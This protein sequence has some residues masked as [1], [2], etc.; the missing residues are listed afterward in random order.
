M[1]TFRDVLEQ[2]GQAGAYELE[3]DGQW[4]T[5]AWFLGARFD[6]GQDRGWLGCSATLDLRPPERALPDGTAG[7]VDV[8]NVK[9][10]HGITLDSS[11]QEVAKVSYQDI[12][13]KVR[14][15]S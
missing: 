5:P 1:A 13:L 7:N 12:T 8:A 10:A 2:L 6:D 4:H 11:G 9:V 3:Y 15:E 14:R